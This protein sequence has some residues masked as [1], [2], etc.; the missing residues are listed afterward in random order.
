MTW[1]ALYPAAQNLLVAARALGLGAAFTLLHQS[2]EAVVRTELGLPDDMLIAA[3]I[4]VGFPVSLP[5]AVRRRPVE[6]VLFRNR[7]RAE[8]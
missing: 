6:E 3:T 7:W 5:G 2:A 8:P 1:T 4:P